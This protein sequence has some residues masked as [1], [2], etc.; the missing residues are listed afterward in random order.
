[1]A[2][3]KPTEKVQAGGYSGALGII[4]L[5]IAGQ[6]GLDLPEPVAGALVLLLAGFGAWLK[7]EGAG[8]ITRGPGKRANRDN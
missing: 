2:S 4:V 5:Y 8:W 6:L 7:T 3:W 1:M